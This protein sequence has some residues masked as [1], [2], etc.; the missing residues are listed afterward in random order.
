MDIYEILT[1]RRSIRKF[2]QTE[3]PIETLKKIVNTGRLAPSAGNLQP[4]EYFI[5]LDSSLREKVFETLSWAKYIRPEGNPQKGEQPMAYI[6]IIVNNEIANS[7]QFKYDVGASIEN[8]IIAALAKGIGCCW[9]GSVNKKCLSKI[10]QVPPN[11][12]IDCVLALGYPL[13]NPICIDVEKDDSIKYYKD[14]NGKLHMPKR[15]LDDIIHIDK[16]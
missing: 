16:F 8:M 7:D 12:S 10:L 2:K 3:I 13:E 11:H 9:I 1:S 5:A 15:K 6:I 4:L 14:L